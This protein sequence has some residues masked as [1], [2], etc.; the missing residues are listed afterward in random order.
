MSTPEKA[1]AERAAPPAPGP[2]RGAA[3]GPPP[4]VFGRLRRATDRVPTKWFTAIGTGLFLAVTAAFGGLAPVAAEDAPLHRLT[5]GETHSNAQVDIAVQ[6]AVLIDELRGSGASPDVEAGERL[7]VLLVELTGARDEPVWTFGTDG[8]QRTIRLAGD[9]RDAVGV[10]REDD[11]TP[12][13]WL[14]PDVPALVA[15]TWTVP[16]D[17]YAEGDLLEVVLSVRTIETGQ[18]LFTGEYWSAPAPA[19][20]V[21]VT[22]EDAGAGAAP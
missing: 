21:S 16:G 14:Q 17:A 20:V 1:P 7:L 5:A 10:V 4:N 2:T 19:A 13:P 8:V 11:Q 6:R 12:N 9:E 15:F 18:L 3:A 22:I